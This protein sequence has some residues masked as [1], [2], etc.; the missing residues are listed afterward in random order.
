MGLQL[1]DRSFPFGPR[2]CMG[3]RAGDSEW[4]SFGFSEKFAAD[5]FHVVR[6]ICWKKSRNTRLPTSFLT[7]VRKKLRKNPSGSRTCAKWQ[8][9]ISLSAV[10]LVVSLQEAQTFFQD[11]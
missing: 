3:A 4:T 8:L 11:T 1:P 2:L 10:H 9:Q 5:L 7:S 6:L